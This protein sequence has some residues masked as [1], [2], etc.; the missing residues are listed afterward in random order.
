MMIDEKLI[1]RV[2]AF[3]APRPLHM[4]RAREIAQITKESAVDIAQITR[5]RAIGN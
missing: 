5:V 3:N 2:G 4:C 1:D